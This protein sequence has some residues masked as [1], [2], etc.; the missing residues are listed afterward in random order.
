MQSTRIRAR[1]TQ[2]TGAILATALAA[3][4][5]LAGCSTTPPE[6]DLCFTAEDIWHGYLEEFTSE[7]ATDETRAQS[8]VV[9]TEAWTSLAGERSATADF[10]HA[11]RDAAN[12]RAAVLNA[13]DARTR[14][15]YQ[16]AFTKTLTTI[17]RS[18]ER[19]GAVID[20]HPAVDPR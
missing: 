15:Q 4:P 18:C 7:Y 16:R 11:L 12:S 6:P 3:A 5:I 20:F 14:V 13:P 17:E 10:A 8:T 2:R 9:L 19:G 1:G